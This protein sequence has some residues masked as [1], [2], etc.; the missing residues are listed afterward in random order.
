MHSLHALYINLKHITKIDYIFYLGQF[1]KFT[2]IPKNTTKK[3][4]AYKEYLHAV[5][6][7]LVYFMERT[8][9]LHNLEEDFKK[10]DTEIDRLIAN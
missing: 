4:G 9:P 1:D 6:D 5:K 2:D 10:S 3:T 7:Y 8:R